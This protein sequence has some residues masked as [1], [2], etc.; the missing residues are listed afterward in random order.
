MNGAT[1]AR[2]VKPK[3]IVICSDG[4]GNSAIKDR[5]TNVFKLYEAVDLNEHLTN[6]RKIPQ[7]AFYD[8]GVGTETFKPLKLLG[9][10]FGFGLSR[11][12]RQLYAALVRCYN[13]GDRIFLFGFSRGAFTV[14]TLGGFI[15][16]CGIL[17][18]NHNITT[19]ADLVKAIEETYKIYRSKYMTGA[20]RHI[21]ALRLKLHPKSTQ[22]SGFETKVAG[23][24]KQNRV[25]D[26]KIAFIGVWDTVDAVG[27]PFDHLADFINYFIYPFKFV[28][29]TLSSKVNQ[30]RHA[31]S[32]DDERHTYHPVLWKESAADRK[33]MKQ[34]WFAG[35]HANVG[36]GY[37]KQ[38]MSLVSLYWMMVEAEKY[39]LRFITED[40]DYYY[41]HQNVNDKLYN[42]RA[43]LAVYYRYKPRNIYHICQVANT[44]AK[45]HETVIG[46]IKQRTEGYAPG[47][48]PTGVAVVTTGNNR[49]RHPRAGAVITNA[50]E[51]DTSLLDRVKPEV[52]VRRLSQYVFVVLSI[53]MLWEAIQPVLAQQ[54]G[55]IAKLSAL[56]SIDG[57]SVLS[58]ELATNPWL[59]AMI[60]VF[61]LVGSQAE[62]NMRRKFSAFW[63]AITPRL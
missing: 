36:G 38:G 4:T 52:L 57:L 55:I 50:Y 31:I 2:S 3:N 62:Q 54:Q 41:Y 53:W 29:L 45:I 11:N 1:Q 59:F 6:P 14:R 58:K 34:V 63:Y 61:Y 35:V 37:T 27:L 48:L 19:D 56:S 47:N 21:R 44:G 7:V 40:W 5:G 17:D 32:I 22:S 60:G 39:G 33:R 18:C 51:R 9:G 13:P 26:G 43:G 28:D 30:A 24:R 23:F 8:D 25:H 20:R 46:R 16:A 15:T 49:T 42:S 10:A 12:V